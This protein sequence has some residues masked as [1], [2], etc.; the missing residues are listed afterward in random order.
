M[1]LLWNMLSDRYYW[2]SD[3]RWRGQWLDDWSNYRRGDYSVGLFPDGPQCLVGTSV[4]M[5]LLG[6]I[7]DQERC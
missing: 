6:D 4:V 2:C 1:S 7:A 5:K 3:G